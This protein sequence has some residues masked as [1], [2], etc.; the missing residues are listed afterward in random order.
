METLSGAGT[1]DEWALDLD[2]VG[3]LLL[4]ALGSTPPA[5][6]SGDPRPR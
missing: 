2:D 3:T 5:D 1:H 6:D 4:A